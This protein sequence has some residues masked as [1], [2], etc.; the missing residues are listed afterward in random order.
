MKYR[1]LGDT[2]ALRLEPG[3]EVIA[4]ILSL[5]ERKRIVLAS[6][7]GLG[8]ASS[9]VV[10]VYDLAAKQ[11]CPNRLEGPLEIASLTGSVTACAGKPY[12]HLHAVFGD[13]EGRAWGG[14]LSEAV[15]SATAEIF[16]R[17]LD[18][19]IGRADDPVTGLKVWDL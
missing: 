6:V 1:V 7:S 8:A 5:C 9:A 17:R 16:L 11:F 14:H 13:R 2:V 12:L 10:G 3:E 19:A 4:S 18:G 15:I